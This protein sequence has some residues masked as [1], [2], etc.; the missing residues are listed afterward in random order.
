MGKK[1]EER[2]RR[3]KGPFNN[4]MRNETK[5]AECFNILLLLGLLK[6][7]A[8][9]FEHEHTAT[10]LTKLFVVALDQRRG[11]VC[12]GKTVVLVL[13][14]RPVM[15][16]KNLDLCQKPSSFFLLARNSTLGWDFN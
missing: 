11:E 14:R 10:L 16:T 2:G 1:G 13:V 7:V 5:E 12:P 3:K 8:P 6:G 15:S 9:V 4:K